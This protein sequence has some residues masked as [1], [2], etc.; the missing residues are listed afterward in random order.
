MSEKK[1]ELVFL[2]DRSGSMG[3]LELDTIGGYNAML[4]KQKKEEGEARVTT[5]LFDHDLTLLHDRIDLPGVSPLTQRTYTVGGSTALLDAMGF[6]MEKIAGVQRHTAPG[7]RAGRVLFV[8]I[9]DG[10]ENAS[11]RY[12]A[13]Q[14]RAMVERYKE[15]YGWEFLFLGANIDA[16][17]AAGGLGI[18]ADRAVN[19]HADSAGTRLNYDA[20]GKAV[21]AMRAGRPLSAEWRKDIDADYRGRKTGR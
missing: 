15:E 3:G 17:D 16:V 14:I 7:Q 1:L 18:Q 5:L 19:Y 20:V 6:A 11:R 4:A 10:L 2:C 12:T 9:T 13:P 21:S 8:I